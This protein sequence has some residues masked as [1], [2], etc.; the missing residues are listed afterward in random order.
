MHFELSEEQNAIYDLVVGFMADKWSGDN[1][2]QGLDSYPCQ[3]PGELVREIA[4]LGFFGISIRENSGGGGEP[5]LTSALIAEA[6]GGGLFPSL[7]TTTLVAAK[8]LELCGADFNWLARL[9]AGQQ[10]V[11]IAIEEPN[12]CWGPDAIE[13][14]AQMDGQGGYLS[15]SKILVADGDFAQ[16]FLVAALLP[17]GPALIRVD[18][19]AGGVQINSMRRLDGQSIVELEM[20]DVRFEQDDVLGDG[21]IL[22]QVYDIWT[23]LIAADLLGNAQSVLRM[24]TDYAKERQQFARP[25]GSFQAVAHRL[26]DIQVD[27]EIGR[28]LLYGACLAL[29]DESAEAEALVSAAKAWMNDLGVKAAE[30]GLQVHGGIGYTWELDIHL[31]LRQAR[32]NAVTLGDSKYHRARVASHLMSPEY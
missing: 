18:A 3:V 16:V 19:D 14:T 11:A 27:V 31:H 24:T 8:A 22:N 20:K 29:E 30:A 2:R 32:S 13:L 25:I 9:I 10:T 26:A 21:A 17:D 1:R 6:A 23:L 12:G 5:L 28:S 4:D 15:G 7:L